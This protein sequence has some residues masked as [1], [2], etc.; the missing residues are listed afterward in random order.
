ML[1]ITKSPV[2]FSFAR[3]GGSIVVARTDIWRAKPT[4]WELVEAVEFN[5]PTKKSET[6]A[7]T[8][9]AG[10]YTC[11]F[12][13]YVEESVNGVYRF[14]LSV[15]KQSTMV[16]SGDANTTPAANDSKVFKDQ[17][18]LRVEGKTK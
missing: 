1:R 17:F 12:Q 9:P 5:D 14:D 3:G 11:V 6:Q 13:C 2:D 16:G 10:E 4:G 7:P 18:V 8:L 15:G